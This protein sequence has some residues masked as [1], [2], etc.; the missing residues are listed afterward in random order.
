M[1]QLKIAILA[2]G[3]GSNFEA[4]LNNIKHGQLDATIQVVISNKASAGAL[5]IARN[6][7]LPAI[8]L[9]S[10]DFPDQEQFD[11]RLLAILRQHDVNF[12]V[13]AGYLKMLS[14]FIVRE[15]KH[16]ILNI[17]PALLPSFG[18]KGMYGHYVHQAV[19]DYGCKVTG[20]TVHLVDEEYDTGPPVLQRCVAVM[21]DDTAESLAERVLKVE[22]QIYT[23]A[24]QLFAED[25]I[26]IDGRRVR[27]KPRL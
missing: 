4:I 14:P 13:L 8:H 21:D 6:N 2:S 3:R 23:E 15:F 20:V 27:V 1:A 18:G 17:H 16:R 25:R 5:E 22:H 19:L 11:Q 26:E 24:L 9:S 10:K 12:I 7:Q